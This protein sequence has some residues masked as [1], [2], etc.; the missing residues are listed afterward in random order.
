MT[1]NWPIHKRKRH[2]AVHSPRAGTWALLFS[3]PIC[4][5][6][7]MG[8]LI[9]SSS[10]CR[11]LSVILSQNFEKKNICSAMVEPKYGK[12]HIH[13]ALQSDVTSSNNI[14]YLAVQADQ[15]LLDCTCYSI[16][17]TV[18]YL[19]FSLGGLRCS[20]RQASKRRRHGLS[21]AEHST[22]NPLHSS[23]WLQREWCWEHLVY[24]FASR[25][26]SG[27]WHSCW[28]SA[29]LFQVAYQDLHVRSRA[30]LMVKTWFFGA[31]T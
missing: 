14:W 29:A 20:H 17:H 30:S 1:W 15:I 16:P 31:T 3:F 11:L 5:S 6:S 25:R 8:P 18:Q 12:H 2:G 22:C 28:R 4:K 27:W 9:C 26:H 13:L 7:D 21:Q 24:T 10:R 19:R 23:L